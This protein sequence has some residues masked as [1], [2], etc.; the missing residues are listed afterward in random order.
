MFQQ[1]H[2]RHWEHNEF[3]PRERRSSGRGKGICVI[4][5]RQIGRWQLYLTRR[6]HQAKSGGLEAV[7]KI[8]SSREF[9][10]HQGQ[11]VGE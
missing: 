5:L 6:Y 3:D 9:K 8:P 7:W 2:D 10:Q 1:H 11:R 4:K